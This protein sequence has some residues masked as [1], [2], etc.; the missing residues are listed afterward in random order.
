MSHKIEIKAAEKSDGATVYGVAYTGGKMFVGGYY[1]PVVVDLS[2]LEIPAEIPLLLNHDNSTDTRIGTVSAVVVDGQLLIDGKILAENEAAQNVIAQGKKGGDWQVSIG[3]NSSPDS[4]VK[5]TTLENDETIIVNG[6]TITAPAEVISGMVLREV[7]IVAVGA[8]KDTRLEIA[9]SFKLEGFESLIAKKGKTMSVPKVEPKVEPVQADNSAEIKAAS[10]SGMNAERN[11]VSEIASLC[12]GEHAELQ[13]KAISEGWTVGLAAQ[14]ILKATREKRPTIA[15]EMITAKNETSKAD[16]LKTL[17]AALNIRA[18]HDENKLVKELGEASVE[19]GYKMRNIGLKEIC[20]ECARI[21]GKP[22]SRA[23]GNDTIRAAF[24]TTSLPY[25]L[26]NTANKALQTAYSAHNVTATILCKPSDVND[27][28]Q[29]NRIRVTD[30]GTLEEV[31]E[32]GEIVNGRMSENNATVQAH[33]YA[34]M[35]TLTEKMVIN[36]DLGAFLEIPSMWGIKS[37]RFVD[38]R[39][40][41]LLLSNPGSFYASGNNN[42]LSGSD[43]VLSASS[44]DAAIVLMRKQLDADGQNINLPPRYLVVPSELEFIAKQLI[45]SKLLA[46]KGS[47]DATNL[48]TENPFATSGIEVVVA[49]ELSNTNY[50]GASSVGW[51]LFTD[52]RIGNSFEISYLRGQRTPVVEQVDLAA[53]ILGI[54][55]RVAFSFGVDDIDPKASVFS[56]GS[57]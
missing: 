10:E 51:Y 33:Q 6:K 27:Y 16:E 7:S 28:K 39:F 23:F 11:R 15:P 19:A 29:A 36:D 13:S 8:D 17:T 1:N 26:G 24:S 48:P 49:P 34:K 12:A 57:A 21:E 2:S 40:Y 22:V 56:K 25:I 50:T 4:G 9:A 5:I 42:Y 20:A 3:A 44:L 55:Y 18:G 30:I 35:F 43:K 52:P 54:G 31:A 53:N 14:E 45:N 38:N 32:N 41:T 47:T 37:A 46:A